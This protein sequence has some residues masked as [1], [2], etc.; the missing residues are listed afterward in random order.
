M[1]SFEVLGNK[2]TAQLL[3]NQLKLIKV[4]VSLGDTETLIEHPAT[5]THAIVPE[6][7]RLKMGITDQMIRL[8]VGLEAWQDI[9]SDLKQALDHIQ[10]EAQSVVSK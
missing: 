2:R 4:A 7:E 5:M 10:A 3:L 9:W 1:I 8:S 6:D